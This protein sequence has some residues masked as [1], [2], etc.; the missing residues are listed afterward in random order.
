MT[1]RTTSRAPSVSSSPTPAPTRP[2]ARRAASVSRRA[3]GSPV[4]VQ[5]PRL[6]LFVPQRLP[7]QT[8]RPHTGPV[9]AKPLPERGRVSGQDWQLPVQVS[10][11]LLRDKLREVNIRLRPAQLLDL[12]LAG[13]QRNDIS[14]TFSTT[15]ADS[16]LVY[17]YGDS[18]GG[19]SDFLAVQL[20]G[21]K[22]TFSFGGARTAITQISV[23]KYIADGRWFKV[24]A[25][26]NNRVASLSV[27]D[28]TESGEYC[29]LCQAG[30]DSCFTKRIG[31]TGTLNFK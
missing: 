11:Q 10:G 18:S 5:Q 9:P 19:R 6:F 25:T 24:T 22:A 14:I 16:L 12:L 23:N 17:N 8:V 27:E 21:G 31:K 7:G 30:D 29:K 13:P 15:K 28:C 2:P 3:T 20:V 4:S 1:A 26:R